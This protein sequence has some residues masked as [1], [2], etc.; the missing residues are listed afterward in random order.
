MGTGAARQSMDVAR[1]AQIG[2]NQ[3]FVYLEKV[4][5]MVR[6]DVNAAHAP[7]PHVPGPDAM[8]GH[9]VYTYINGI[10][11]CREGHAAGCGH[12]T[13]GSRVTYLDI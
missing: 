12:P 13:T 5:W 10:P 2:A 7:P 3:S 1:G 11:V 4:L 8:V 6:G 9:S